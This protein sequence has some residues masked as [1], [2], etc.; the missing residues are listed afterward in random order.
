MLNIQL[1]ANSAA[2]KNFG[3]PLESVDPQWQQTRIL[4]D[5]PDH[6]G[7]SKKHENA[8][9]KAGRGLALYKAVSNGDKVLARLLLDAGADVD[10]RPFCS[11][12]ALTRAVTAGDEEMVQMLLEKKPNLEAKPTLGATALYVAVSNEA[13]AL[14]RLLLIHGANPNA[15]TARG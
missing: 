11:I 7:K 5:L 3:A 8:N 4:P 10:S 14:V 12:P 13:T 2:E 9:A 1:H 15:K 6:Q